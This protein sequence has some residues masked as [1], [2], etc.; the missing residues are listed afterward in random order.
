[1]HYLRQLMAALF[2]LCDVSRPPFA[3]IALIASISPTGRVASD[4]NSAEIEIKAGLRGA[5]ERIIRCA[6][7]QNEDAL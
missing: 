7:T 4:G 3:I 6:L 5:T 2:A 1:V